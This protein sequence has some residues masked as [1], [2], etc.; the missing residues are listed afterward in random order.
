M[1][2]MFGQRPLNTQAN[3]LTEDNIE[4]QK[5]SKHKGNGEVE[6][7]AKEWSIGRRCVRKDE[8]LCDGVQ[9][10]ECPKG[11]D[12]LFEQIER[13]YPLIMRE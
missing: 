6:Q 10:G 11:C 12:S 2:S 3:G 1:H 4:E 13:S 5:I 7:S 9:K 8:A